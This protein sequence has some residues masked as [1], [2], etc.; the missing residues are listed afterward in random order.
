MRFLLFNIQP[1]LLAPFYCGCTLLLHKQVP[2]CTLNL[3]LVRWLGVGQA[4]LFH[5]IP[6]A[7]DTQQGRDELFVSVSVRARAVQNAGCRAD[8][9]CGYVGTPIINT[10]QPKYRLCGTYSI[11]I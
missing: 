2:G 11:F 10:E 4:G 9:V 8:Q 6:A 7:G 3:P 1:L 5:S